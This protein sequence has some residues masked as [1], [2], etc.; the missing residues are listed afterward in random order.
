MVVGSLAATTVGVAAQEAPWY[1]GHVVTFDPNGSVSLEYSTPDLSESRASLV[2]LLN[3]WASS[4][5]EVVS[6]STQ[7][8]L[9]AE[10]NGYPAGMADEWLVILKA[11][12]E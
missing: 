10:T 9:D 11:P 5:Y 3:D 12:T 8:F 6:V 7:G 2:E 4:G 1:E